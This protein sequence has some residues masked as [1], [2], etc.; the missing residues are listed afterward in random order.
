MSLN[1][2]KYHAVMNDVIH[3]ADHVYKKL[4]WLAMWF[5]RI[6]TKILLPPASF[7]VVEL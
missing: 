4:Q 3:A 6:G 2:S 1:R 5:Y 7:S